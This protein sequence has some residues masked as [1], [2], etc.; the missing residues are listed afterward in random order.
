M[1]DHDGSAAPPLS[2]PYYGVSFAEAV[3]RG[4]RKWAVVD[5]RAGF[6]EYWWFVLFVFLVTITLAGLDTLISGGNGEGGPLMWAAALFYLGSLVPV[7]TLTIRRLHDTG[8]SGWMYL[9]GFIPL[10]G[11]FI[12][13]VF[14]CGGTRVEAQRFGPPY[15]DPLAAGPIA[16]HE[17]VA[18]TDDRPHTVASGPPPRGRGPALLIGIVTAATL[19]V[20]AGAVWPLASMYQAMRSLDSTTS[21][22]GGWSDTEPAQNDSTSDPGTSDSESTWPDPTEAPATTWPDVT[23]EAT[24]TPSPSST[25]DPPRRPDDTDQY[26]EVWDNSTGSAC[27]TSESKTLWGGYPRA[28]CR[29][30]KSATGATTGEAIAKGSHH[31][32]CQRDL[33]IDNPVYTKTQSNT[34]WVWTESTSG[35][36]DWFPE[37]A[38][39]QGESDQAING[40]A[41]CQ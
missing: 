17:P 33:S 7:I 11:S 34:W 41:I 14:L 22:S 31:I 4:Y 23:D 35:T 2:W 10:A 37:T 8:R 30:W 38:I 12:L 19:V 40:I 29:F 28:T 3:K 6:G 25:L 15:Y 5:G 27:T 9:C 21:A 36:W 20:V 24:E 13:F 18:T 32:A 26:A 1:N 16:V 39:A